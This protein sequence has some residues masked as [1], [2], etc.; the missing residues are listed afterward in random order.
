MGG[1]S[2]RAFVDVHVF[3]PFAPSNAA[4]SLSACYKKH[5]NI[6]KRAYGQ[7]IRENEHASFTPVVMS[8][9]GGLA[10][11]TTY[12]YIHLASLLP[13]KWGDEYSVVMGWLRYSLSFSLLRSAIQCIRGAP[14]SFQHHVAAPPLMDLV[15]VES[16]L[17]LEDDHGGD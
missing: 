4:S 14:S 11:E 9:T 15:R 17:S 12:F 6:K 3:N 7:R 2:E 10:H 8:A 1:R 5:K 13:R 16:N